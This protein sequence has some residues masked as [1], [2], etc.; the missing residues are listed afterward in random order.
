MKDCVGSAALGVPEIVTT[1]NVV[2]HVNHEGTA[3]DELIEQVVGVNPETVR[4]VGVI[5]VPTGPVY[6]FGIPVATAFTVM[7]KFEEVTVP[8]VL[9]ALNLYVLVGFALVGVP[10]KEPVVGLN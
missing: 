7:V 6:E 3:A 1:P 2:L 8:S 5:A 10:I 4:V 9:A